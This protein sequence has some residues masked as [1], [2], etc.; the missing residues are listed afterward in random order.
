M[1]DPNPYGLLYICLI[2]PS[3]LYK[4]CSLG[5]SI[6]NTYKHGTNSVHAN[7]QTCYQNRIVCDFAACEKLEWMGIKPSDL[8]SIKKAK[9][10][11]KFSA[12]DKSVLWNLY[13]YYKKNNWS[14][15]KEV[16]LSF[17][18]IISPRLARTLHHRKSRWARTL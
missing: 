16:P 1:S 14:E 3:F 8:S 17:F 11:K 15:L 18:P 9:S 2:L 7:S 13:S 10:G 5:F 4:W 12:S 6:F